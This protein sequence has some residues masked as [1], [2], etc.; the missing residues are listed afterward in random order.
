VEYVQNGIIPRIC[1]NGSAIFDEHILGRPLA[2]TAS[3]AFALMFFVGDLKGNFQSEWDPSASG[4]D[5]TA[6]VFS[7]GLVVAAISFF[8]ND[9]KICTQIKWIIAL[10]LAISCAVTWTV[11]TPYAVEKITRF[12]TLSLISA[13]LPAFIFTRPKEV[14]LFIYSVVGA[15]FLISL[16]GLFQV[17]TG[18]NVNGRI[19]GISAD[20]VGL[21]RNAGI[22]LVGLYAVVSCGRKKRMWLG[23]FCL[24]LL[25]VL[26]ASGSRGPAFFALGI[27]VLITV[28]W[29]RYNLRGIAITIAIFAVATFVIYQDA[30]VLPKLTLDRFAFIIEHRWDSSAE[31]RVIAGSAAIEEIGRSPLG[32]GIGGFGQVYNFGSV[33][34]RVYP[35]NIVLEIAVEDGWMVGILFLF[36][37]SIGILRSYRAAAVEPAFRS[38]FAIF[39]FAI[40]NAL[41]SG[42]MNDNRIVYALL[43][44][45]LMLPQLMTKS[46]P[47]DR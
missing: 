45:A 16:A 28:F 26:I 3:I 23:V 33:T 18:T 46:L 29:A 12:F 15:G 2:A 7:L 44:I 31:E 30:S 5:L 35:H 10:F 21:G 17:I 1:R 43:C 8:A 22:A 40:C 47:A 4:I 6:A 25:L 19:S 20:T 27:I 37:A 36:I 41:V 42:D 34:D 9:G 11:L 13:T 38:F 39:L 32:L 24:P 14:R